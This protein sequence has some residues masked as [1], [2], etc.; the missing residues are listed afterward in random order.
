MNNFFLHYI[1][2]RLY[3][4][5][6][7]IKE[8]E[9][10]GVNRCL[11]LKIIKKFSWGDRI[12]LATF[13]PQKV[14]IIEQQVLINGK[15]EKYDGR[16]NRK[17]GKGE[18]FGYFDIRGLNLIASNEF[19][20]ALTSQLN[21]ISTKEVNQGVQR[22]CGS[23]VISSAH[24]VTD[25]IADIIKKAEIL[26]KEKQEKVKFFVT[27]KFYPLTAI[28][29]NAT[30]TRTIIEV[31]ITEELKPGD[32]INETVI[33]MIEN[34]NKRAYIKTHEKRGRPRKNENKMR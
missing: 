12:L 15:L 27:G 24:T 34:Y 30:F 23:Y 7:F 33:G 2:S 11:P 21:I 14:D 31:E 22:Q 6:V 4:K 18:V 29:D 16:K 3:P 32:I 19:K 17:G 5:E 28:I 8:A 26:S 13:I 9:K 25:S 20:T 10:F 1:G